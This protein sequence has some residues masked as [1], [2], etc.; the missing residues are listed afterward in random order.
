VLLVSGSDLFS[1][2]FEDARQSRCGDR[3]LGR[4]NHS[5]LLRTVPIASNSSALHGHDTG[6]GGLFGCGLLLA[7]VVL[8][9]PLSLVI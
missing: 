1:R 2:S 3:A 8:S 6:A 5:V 4:S 9:L 7:L